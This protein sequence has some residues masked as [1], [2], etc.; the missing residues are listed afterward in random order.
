MI[1]NCMNLRERN[2]SKKKMS[3]LVKIG[4]RLDNILN[5]VKIHVPKDI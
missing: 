1:L 4:K 5:Y 3:D 2:T